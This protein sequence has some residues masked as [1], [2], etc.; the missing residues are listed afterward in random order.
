[1]KTILW[2]DTILLLCYY[3]WSGCFFFLVLCVKDY[4]PPSEGQV[5]L[6]PH[7]RSHQ[8]DPMLTLLARME[9]G[10]PIPQHTEVTPTLQSSLITLYDLGAARK[11]LSWLVFMSEPETDKGFVHI[12]DSRYSNLDKLFLGTVC[13]I[14]PALG[15]SHVS[16]CVE[17]YSTALK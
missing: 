7:R 12:V 14:S 9:Q 11:Q 5:I 16:C 10:P 3:S 6:R 17:P 1:M 13:I 8:P 15:L 4:D 2:F